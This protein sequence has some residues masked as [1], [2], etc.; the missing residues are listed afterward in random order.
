MG[1]CRE[2][3]QAHSGDPCSIDVYHSTPYISAA[4]DCRSRKAAQVFCCRSRNRPDQTQQRVAAD[5]HAQERG[6]AGS[7]L[8]AQSQRDNPR[9]TSPSRAVR[10]FPDGATPGRRS[11]EISTL[12][13]CS[14]R[15]LFR[16]LLQV[17]L[18]GDIPGPKEPAPG[19]GLNRVQCG[20]RNCSKSGGTQMQ[21]F[22]RQISNLLILHWSLGRRS[23]RGILDQRSCHRF[24]SSFWR[25]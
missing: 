16:F 21:H 12:W 3:V 23:S 6:S 7:A 18:A 15:F 13:C 17:P 20:D 8:A 24:L 9:W 25:S 11:V 10:R 14:Q 4:P 5:R 2:N 22:Q 1:K 19:S